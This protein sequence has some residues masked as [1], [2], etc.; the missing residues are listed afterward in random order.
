VEVRRYQL[1]L[2]IGVSR[3]TLGQK[4]QH[5][6]NHHF[7]WKNQEQAFSFFPFLLLFSLF[8]FALTIG[9]FVEYI[10]D[11]NIYP[12]QLFSSLTTMISGEFIQHY[13]DT[14]YLHNHKCSYKISMN[15]THIQKKKKK[16]K[17]CNSDGFWFQVCEHKLKSDRWKYGLT[18]IRKERLP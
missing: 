2:W 15:Q 6:A 10:L 1:F 8:S 11:Y 3:P 17:L 18:Y 14:E 12:L 7:D 16:T 9:A 4:K 5:T 13:E